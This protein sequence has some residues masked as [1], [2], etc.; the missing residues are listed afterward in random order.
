MNEQKARKLIDLIID[1]V[2]GSTEVVERKITY[3]SRKY[4]IEKIS[5][6]VLNKQ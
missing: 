5:F 3:L 1:R 6:D 4:K 2:T